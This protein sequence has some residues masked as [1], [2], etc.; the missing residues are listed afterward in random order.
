MD[1]QFC[2]ALFGKIEYALVSAKVSKKAVA[3]EL[4]ISST[5]LSKQFNRLKQGKGINL[6]TLRVIEKLTGEIFFVI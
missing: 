4:G 3:N 5:S 6:L 1:K 2:T